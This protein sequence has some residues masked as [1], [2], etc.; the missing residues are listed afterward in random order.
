MI[1]QLLKPSLATENLRRLMSK[2]DNRSSESGFT[3]IELMIATAVLSTMI[4]VVTV[5][6]I[7]I[8]TLYDKGINQSRTQD[9]VRDITDQIGQDLKFNPGGALIDPAPLNVAAGGTGNQAPVTV[10]IHSICTGTIRYSYIVGYELGSSVNATDFGN[11]GSSLNY[12][13]MPAIL[14]RDNNSGGTGTCVPVNLLNPN[15]I[16]TSAANN[17]G[18]ELAPA[19]TRLTLFQVSGASP[20]TIDVSL[21]Y[22]D[23]GLLTNY[24]PPTT[25]PSK[26]TSVTCDGDTGDQFCATAGLETVVVERIQ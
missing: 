16:A 21:A 24:S 12:P 18:T 11:G 7:N 1:R 6:I 26:V 4:L 25:H 23:Y 8:G 22:G 10:T 2:K 19:N 9:A 5:I 14:W 15:A 20:Y 13:T 3:I 17:N